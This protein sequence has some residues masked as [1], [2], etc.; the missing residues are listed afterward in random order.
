M[1]DI[2]EKHLWSRCGA[3]IQTGEDIT[4]EAV[5][6]LCTLRDFSKGKLNLVGH[7]SALPEAIEQFY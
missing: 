6:C 2:F 3:G 7:Q 1:H 4:G 5:V